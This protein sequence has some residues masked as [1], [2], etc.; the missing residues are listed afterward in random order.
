MHET[1]TKWHYLD[2]DPTDLPKH[3]GWYIICHGTEWTNGKLT[4]NSTKNYDS[5]IRIKE[6]FDG[7][8]INAGM[9]IAWCEKPQHPYIK[10]SE[11]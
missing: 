11:E 7:R 1:K 9:V 3:N 6:F 8:W 4:H 5:E 2:K 10:E